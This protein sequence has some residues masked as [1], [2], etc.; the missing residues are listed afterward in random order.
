MIRLDGEFRWLSRIR[1]ERIDA[2]LNAADLGFF[3]DMEQEPAIAAVLEATGIPYTGSPARAGYISGDKLASKRLLATLGVPVPWVGLPDDE[4]PPF[5]VVLKTRFGHNSAGMGTDSVCRNAE[6]LRRALARRSGP[7]VIEEYID[8]PEITAGFVGRKT[9]PQFRLDFEGFGDLPRI[10]DWASKWDDTSEQYKHSYPVPWPSDPEID[11]TMQRVA[12]ALN[13]RDYG[14]CDLR[15]RNGVGFVI[16]VNTNPDLSKGAGLHRMATKAGLSYAE[17][18]G[19]VIEATLRRV[20]PRGSFAYLAR[21]LDGLFMPDGV[22][23]VPAGTPEEAWARASLPAVIAYEAPDLGPYPS[24]AEALERSD[25]AARIRP[26]LPL[27]IPAGKSPA[28]R[29][30]AARNEVELCGTDGRDL[31]DKIV[32]DRLLRQLDIPVPERDPKEG[33][34]VVQLPDSRGGEGTFF[35]DS[36]AEVSRLRK[37]HGR[38]LVRRRIAGETLGVTIRIEDSAGGPPFRVSPLRRQ[39]TRAG[40]FLGIEWVATRAQASLNPSLRRLAEHLRSKQMRGWFSFDVV[41]DADEKAWFIECNPRF[42]AATPQILQHKLL[43][44]D[45]VPLSEFRGVALDFTGAGRVGSTW[46]T[47]R[48]DAATLTYLGPGLPAPH[49][50]FVYVFARSGQKA[51][52]EDTLATILSPVPVDLERFVPVELH[53]D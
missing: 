16:D 6:E 17:M 15:L 46:R 40:V 14:R 27:L 53:G 8:G 44:E 31:E 42:T 25:I 10:L 24:S 35:V 19:E 26:G 39:L 36:A 9:L 1:R 37:Q 43:G 52:P 4:A 20:R 49:E 41:V 47:G 11:R 51:Q 5:P 29:V 34:F 38:V 18:I 32:F 7:H 30:W 13:I 45:I 33:P 50:A 3:L 28:L 23:L 48:Y 21:G 22:A 2:V 12:A